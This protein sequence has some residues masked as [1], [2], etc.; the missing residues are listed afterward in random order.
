MAV[1]SIFISK[2][3]YPFFEER[4]VQLEWFGG[5]ALSQK[6]K[7]EIGLHN[8]FLHMY[9]D[10]KTLEVSCASTNQLGKRLSA[11]NLL[12]EVNVVIDGNIHKGITSVESVFQSSRV[13]DDGN[14]QIGPFPEYIMV[15][16]QDS[17]KKV[18]EASKGLHSYRYFFEDTYFYAPEYHISLFYDFVYMNA[19]LE[20]SNA[21]VMRQL[22]EGEYT[23]F[24]DL[25]TLSL[26]SQARSCAIFVGLYKAGLLD[27]IRNTEN[28]LKLFRTKNDGSAGEGAYLNAHVFRNGKVNLFSEVVP[29]F[30]CKKEVEDI[31]EKCF[32]HLTNRKD[33]EVFI[34]YLIS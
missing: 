13:Y 17:K 22:V 16:G 15:S 25:A 14:E 18:K 6:R 10:Y 1:R 30:Y 12:K 3:E 21:D 5:F 26:N 24:S 31:Y 9:P 32:S 34:P 11:M 7:C 33:K 19:L 28:Y 27:E 20:D 8:N 29:C 23:A 4:K 2:T